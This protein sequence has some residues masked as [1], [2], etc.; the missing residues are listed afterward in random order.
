MDKVALLK[1]D[2]YDLEKVE[3]TIRNGFELLGGNSFL[4]K[5]I[6]YNSKVLLKPNMLSIENEGSP[7][8]TNSVV[9]KQ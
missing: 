3:K 1:C 2:E 5:L 8:V 4:N 6:P 7:V 9:L